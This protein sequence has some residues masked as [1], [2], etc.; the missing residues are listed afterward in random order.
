MGGTS[1]VRGGV[2]GWFLCVSEGLIVFLFNSIIE[3]FGLVYQ[4]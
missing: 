3:F 1:F 4:G 2:Q